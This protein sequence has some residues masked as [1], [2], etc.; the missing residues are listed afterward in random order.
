MRLVLL[1][2]LMIA[3]TNVASGTERT[4]IIKGCIP[5][6]LSDAA[7]F[8]V[9]KFEE[10]PAKGAFTGR[11]A[12]VILDSPEAKHFRTMLRRGAVEGPN[13]A[14]HYTIVIWGCG[15]GCASFAIV[16]AKSG[17]V[18][19]PTDISALDINHVDGDGLN[20]RLV[21]RLLIVVGAPDEKD[22]REGITYYEWTGKE[23]KKLLFI[24]SVKT[25]CPDRG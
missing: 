20:Y 5:L 4:D 13:F 2:L 16:D 23:L 6:T 10:Y 8:R 3:F 24:R 21:S 12:A 11:P 1:V 22:S 14:G 19:F 7:A 18:Y 9:P 17:H 15:A 25:F